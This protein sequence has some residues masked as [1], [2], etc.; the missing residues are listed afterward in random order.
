MLGPVLR[1]WEVR[2][3]RRFPRVPIGRQDGHLASA[4][5][6]THDLTATAPSRRVVG[7]PAIATLS[8]HL[9]STFVVAPLSA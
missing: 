5:V 2:T 1:G 3:V 6:L 4:N 7:A 8:A 9:C